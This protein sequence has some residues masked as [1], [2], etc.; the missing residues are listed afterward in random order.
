MQIQASHD[1]PTDDYLTVAEAAIFL[2]VS[3]ATIW[4][5]ISKGEIPAYRFGARRILLKR[6]ELEGSLKPA[7][8]GRQKGETMKRTESEDNLTQWGMQPL[9]EEQKQQA[10]QALKEAKMLRAEMLAK[11]GGKLFSDSTEIIREQREE[12]TAQ[13][14]RAAGRE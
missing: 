2:K 14:E 9:T 8:A 5:R 11:R 12:R 1:M 10:L 7:R 6:A 13:L 3:Q 4:R